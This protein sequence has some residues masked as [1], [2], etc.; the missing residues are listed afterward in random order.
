M[1]SGCIYPQDL[2]ML[3]SNFFALRKLSSIQLTCLIFHCSSFH[4]HHLLQHIKER[5]CVITC[6]FHWRLIR[7]RFSVSC[8]EHLR[9]H[10]IQK[11]NSQYLFWLKYFLRQWFY[12]QTFYFKLQYCSSVNNMMMK[13]WT[14]FLHSLMFSLSN[15]MNLWMILLSF[16]NFKFDECSYQYDGKKLKFFLWH[17]WRNMSMSSIKSFYWIIN[18]NKALNELNCDWWF[19]ESTDASSFLIII[20]LNCSII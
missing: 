8:C 4:H 15:D 11:W 2:M 20:L 18:G 19:V 6:F 5:W 13:S 14:N 10:K 16:L 17:V 12:H 1:K 7:M 3:T 9:I